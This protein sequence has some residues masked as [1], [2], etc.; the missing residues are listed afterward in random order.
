V[1]AVRA[2]LPEEETRPVSS[3][4]RSVEAGALAE[5]V[6]KPYGWQHVRD[7]CTSALQPIATPMEKL[8]SR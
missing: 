2:F 1:C 6:A 4:Y 5:E 3:A 7:R 8:G